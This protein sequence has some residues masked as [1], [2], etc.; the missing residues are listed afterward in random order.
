MKVYFLILVSIIFFGCASS[1]I[2]LID[3]SDTEVIEYPIVGQQTTKSLGE[4]LVAKGVQNTSDAIDISKATQFNKEEGEASVLTCAV[5]VSP[6][7]FYKRGIY[8]SEL[9]RADCFGPV[10]YQL[11]LSDG[12]TNWNCPGNDGIADI[13]RDKNNKYFLA[14][15]ASQIE[16]KQDHENIKASKK[17]VEFKDNFIQE[18]IYNGKVGNHMKFIYREF[19][20]SVA[21]PAFTQEVQYDISESSIVGF[22]NVRL[23]VIRATNTDIVYKLINNF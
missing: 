11:T 10:T 16:L 23:E 17:I 9:R 14:V 15:L 8:E 20:D 21:R 12:T 7:T 18:L 19:S 1:P 13:C 2:K 5:T 4:R 22:K 3:S 6:G